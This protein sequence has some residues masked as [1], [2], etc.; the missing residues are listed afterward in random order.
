MKNEKKTVKFNVNGMHCKSCEMLIKDEISDIPGVDTVS[1][2]HKTGDGYLTAFQEIDRDLILK[3]I[4]NAGYKG[5]VENIK[6]TNGNGKVAG[7]VIYDSMLFKNILSTGISIKGSVKKD[8]KG[9]LVI[10]YLPEIDLSDKKILLVDEIVGTGDSLK[11]VSK[12]LIDK[13]K[14]GEL[15]TM[16][17]VVLKDGQ[18]Y[19]DFYSLKES[20]DWVV[21]PWDRYEFP[22]YF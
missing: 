7:Q 8:E 5:E 22:E 3:A 18:F 4:T 16:T 20:G 14:I 6:E 21:F 17:L 19:P 15:K 11:E 12:I 10:S 2:D 13:Y 9:E 1:V